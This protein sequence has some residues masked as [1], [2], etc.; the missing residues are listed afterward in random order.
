MMF[1]G[2]AGGCI[3][4]VFCFTLKIQVIKPATNKA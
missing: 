2:R 1:M 3:R 4:T